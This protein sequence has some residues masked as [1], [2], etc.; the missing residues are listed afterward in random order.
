MQPW[1]ETAQDCQRACVPGFPLACLPRALQ[2]ARQQ[3]KLGGAV[4]GE[5]AASFYLAADRLRVPL[6]RSCGQSAGGE[7]ESS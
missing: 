1:L 2:R 3:F 5:E 7:P 4:Q 6:G